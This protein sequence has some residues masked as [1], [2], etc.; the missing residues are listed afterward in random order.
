MTGSPIFLQ[1]S[2]K[3]PVYARKMPTFYPVL[4]GRIVA[5]KFWG[6][7]EIILLLNKEKSERPGELEARFL[8]ILQ[9]E[10]RHKGVSLHQ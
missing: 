10:V 7:H 3:C 6:N 9:L 4:C 1:M 2:G 5:W 8:F